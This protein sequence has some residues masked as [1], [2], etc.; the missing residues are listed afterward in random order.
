[1]TISVDWS[2]DELPA[3]TRVQ[4]W[5]MAGAVVL[6]CVAVTVAA[7]VLARDGAASPPAAGPSPTR[8]PSA[9]ATEP[10]CDA[11]R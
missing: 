5:A 8:E 6:V 1:M 9:P 7:L 4:K 2:V 11:V 3:P 10:S